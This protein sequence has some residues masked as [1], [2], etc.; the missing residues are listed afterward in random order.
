MERDTWHVQ[1]FVLPIVHA[2]G[3]RL[4]HAEYADSNGILALLFI[5]VAEQN[6]II[7]HTLC[8]FALNLVTAT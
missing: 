5:V 7:L 3:L 8:K 4:L 2:E 1:T 6:E